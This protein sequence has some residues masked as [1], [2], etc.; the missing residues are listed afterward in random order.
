MCMGHIG[1]HTRFKH[2]SAIS[3]GTDEHVHPCGLDR[4]FAACIHSVWTYLKAQT[5][6]Y[7]FSPAVSSSMGIE[8]RYLRICDKYQILCAGLCSIQN[9]QTHGMVGNFHSIKNENV[10]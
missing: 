8:W 3:E 6:N 10:I 7:I 2:L 1:Q 9:I 5:K 4:A